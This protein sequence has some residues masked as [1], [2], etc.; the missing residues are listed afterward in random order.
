LI[1]VAPLDPSSLTE[2]THL[3]AAACSFDRADVVAAEKLFG[4][5]PVLPPPPPIPDAIFDVNTMPPLPFGAWDGDTLVGVASF[6]VKHIRILA[7]APDA[8]G[9]GVGSALLAACEQAARDTGATQIRALDL[10][11]NYLAPGIDVD[12]VDT[13]A[14]LER[15]GFTR[16]P[17]PRTN[18]LIDV[19]GNPRVTAERTAELAD[20]AAQRGYVVRRARAN[21]IELLDAVAREFG[22]AWPFELARALE[23]S[24]VGVH[25]ALKDEAYCAFAAHDGNNRGLG[26]FGPTGT[27][28]AHR[29]QGLGEA[30]LLACLLDVG[31]VHPQCEVAWIGPRPFYEKV[32]GIARDRHFAVMSKPL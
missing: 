14:W 15:R 13:I 2:A 21:E 28:P 18:V 29:G 24:P 25:V 6:A 9:H 19:Q 16:V 3:L 30:L 4:P 11:G 10:P 17:E 5:R 1:R 23:H 26:W 32:A 8:R 20:R 27:W 22:G 7:V 31:T 12:N